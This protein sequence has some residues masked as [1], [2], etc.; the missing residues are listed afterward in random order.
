MICSNVHNLANYNYLKVCRVSSGWQIFDKERLLTNCQNIIDVL[1]SFQDYIEEIIEKFSIKHSF[2][3]LHGGCISDRK[4]DKSI[5]LIGPT[6]A[7]KSS[8]VVGAILSRKFDFISDDLI[9]FNTSSGKIQI[10]PQIVFLRDI[11]LFKNHINDYCFAQG[12]SEFR[13]EYIYALSLPYPV[14]SLQINMFVLINR[15]AQPCS[16]V[17]SLNSSEKYESLLLNSK[18][19][20]QVSSNRMALLNVAKK[21]S[22]FRLEYQSIEDGVVGLER[23]LLEDRNP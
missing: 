22:I 13:K 23:V 15:V 10:F 6:H 2:L 12:Y 11:T 16:C 20:Q 14:K 5:G 18:F 3:C 8:L 21:V 17:H 7:G 4:T 19:V 1:V 9:L